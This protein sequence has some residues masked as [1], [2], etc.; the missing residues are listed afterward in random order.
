MCLNCSIIT[1]IRHNRLS[2]HL[3]SRL[4]NITPCNTSWWSLDLWE[5][6]ISVTTQTWLRAYRKLQDI[7]P[8]NKR[9]EN[10]FSCIPL[11]IP[12]RFF[13]SGCFL[14]KDEWYVL[15]IFPL[16]HIPTSCPPCNNIKIY[17]DWHKLLFITCFLIRGT[18]QPISP[19]TSYFRMYIVPEPY[20]LSVY[21]DGI[22]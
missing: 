4:Q 12:F 7:R 3:E 21:F 8:W 11:F 9:M 1:I 22:W 17:I 20:W 14:K 19:S 15:Y 13:F 16:T 5:L 2:P 18:D 10:W 6:L